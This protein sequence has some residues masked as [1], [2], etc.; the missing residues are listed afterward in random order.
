MLLNSQFRAVGIG[1]ALCFGR[2]VD[3]FPIRVQIILKLPIT[4]LLPPQDFFDLPTA[5]QELLRI[6]KKIK[7]GLMTTKNEKVGLPPFA[8]AS[9]AAPPISG[10]GL[11]LLRV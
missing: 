9:N 6:Q 1:W 2:S 5:L 3:P 10:R 4:L 8:A 7:R 11:V